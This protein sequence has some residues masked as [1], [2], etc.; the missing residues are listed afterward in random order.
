ME[1]I[2]AVKSAVEIVES[3]TDS[4]SAEEIAESVPTLKSVVVVCCLHAERI[5]RDENRTWSNIS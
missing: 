3:I 2:V 5:T 1:S 4:R